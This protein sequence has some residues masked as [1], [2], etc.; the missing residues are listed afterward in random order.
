MGSPVWLGPLYGSMSHAVAPQRV[1]FTLHVN[2]AGL[3]IAF[4][5]LSQCTPVVWLTAYAAPTLQ[6]QHQRYLAVLSCIPACRQVHQCAGLYTNVLG[7]TSAAV[8]AGPVACRS[9]AQSAPQVTGP[10]ATTIAGGVPVLA[11]AA[12]AVAAAPTLVPAPAVAPA[13]AATPPAA[14]VTPPAPAPALA[15]AQQHQL[16]PSHLTWAGFLQPLL[17]CLQQRGHCPQPLRVC[18]QWQRQEQ[19]ARMHTA[20]GRGWRGRALGLLCC[21]GH[22]LRQQQHCLPVVCQEA[23]LLLVL[24]SCRHHWQVPL[25]QTCPSCT[26]R[27][28]VVCV[29]PPA[30]GIQPPC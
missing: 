22:W 11:T 6:A 13:A 30:T 26:S 24:I 5:E 9:S 10:G 8:P 7:F 21:H 15:P 18:L 29:H 23:L 4:V 17:C 12:A 27:Q 2:T 19:Q 3:R 20:F 25:W 1:S 14:A 16:Y 28:Q